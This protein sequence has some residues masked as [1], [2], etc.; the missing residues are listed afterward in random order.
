MQHLWREL[1]RSHVDTLRQAVDRF[2]HI[3]DDF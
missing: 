3:V 1:A 2:D